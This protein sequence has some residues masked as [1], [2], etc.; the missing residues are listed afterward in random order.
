MFAEDVMIPYTSIIC[1][2]PESTMGFASALMLKYNVSSVLITRQDKY[3][4]FLTKRDVLEAYHT[5]LNPGTSLVRDLMKKEPDLIYVRN[6]TTLD[7]V[8][9]LMWAK[10]C[11]HILVKNMDDKVSGLI[12]SIDMVKILS[13]VTQIPLQVSLPKLLSGS[14]NK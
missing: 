14:L 13:N 4:G 10:G 7:R 8:A 9:D 5:G 3:F 6:E 12:S 11:H 2:T 1:A